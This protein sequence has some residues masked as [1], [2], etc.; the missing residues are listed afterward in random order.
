MQKLRLAV[1]GLVTLAGIGWPWWCIVQFIKETEALGLTDPIEIV[2]LFSAGVWA[3][4]S[5]GF[6][7]ADLTLVLIASFLFYAVEGMR[8]GMKRWYLYIP[9]TFAISFAFSFGLFMFNREKLMGQGAATV[10]EA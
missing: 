2:N 4:A 8:I 7:A 1:Y 6:I 3:N 5:A 10:S 9:A